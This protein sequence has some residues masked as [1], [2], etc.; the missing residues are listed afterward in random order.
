MQ[1]DLF[2]IF[3]CQNWLFP[4]SFTP[5]S[6]PPAQALIVLSH[7]VLYQLVL[8][9]AHVQMHFTLSFSF[10]HEQCHANIMSLPIAFSVKQW[11]FGGSGTISAPNTPILG[12]LDQSCWHLITILH[13]RWK[14]LVFGNEVSLVYYNWAVSL[15][16]SST[17]TGQ[18]FM[19]L[20]IYQLFLQRFK[21]RP[22]RSLPV[23]SVY[24]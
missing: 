9:A 22:L 1:H 4:L 10:Q 2:C 17:L 12:L 21:G 16:A 8:G 18:V 23:P 20:L 13:K 6:G 3:N 14:L 5:P 24:L 15:V 7:S 11:L 19:T